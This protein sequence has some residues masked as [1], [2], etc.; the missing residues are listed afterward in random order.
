MDLL[1]VF[2]ICPCM[3]V[4]LSVFLRCIVSAFVANKRIL[5]SLYIAWK[6]I[7]P[8]NTRRNVG[9]QV[10]DTQRERDADKRD[11]QTENNDRKQPIYATI[12]THRIF[13]ELF[14]IFGLTL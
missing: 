9:L 4:R 3:T 8:Y 2:F 11:R 14:R 6:Q 13:S 12:R 5:R 1:T 10:E 7:K